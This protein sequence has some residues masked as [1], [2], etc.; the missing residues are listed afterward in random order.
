MT[1][2]NFISTGLGVLVLLLLIWSWRKTQLTTERPL[3]KIAVVDGVR[4]KTEA[5]PFLDVV[6]IVRAETEQLENELNKQ[7]EQ[8]NELW[9]KTERSLKDKKVS[10]DIRLVLRKQLDQKTIEM[11]ADFRARKDAFRKKCASLEQLLNESVFEV[12]NELAKK[13]KLTL[14]LNTKIVDMMTVFYAAPS[15][16]LTDEVISSLNKKLKNINDI[17]RH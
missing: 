5:Q 16:D 15:I 7:R 11:D 10:E 9:E 12:I 1:K 4:L 2:H 6:T 3:L 13:Y 8:R 17:V 14:I